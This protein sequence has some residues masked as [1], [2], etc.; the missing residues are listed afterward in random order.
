M[1][2]KEYIKALIRRLGEGDPAAL[3]R[4]R[5]VVGS[6]R[7]RIT[8]DA[9]TVEVRFTKQGLV[10]RT[11]LSNS[12][13]G[14]GLTDRQT[15]LDILD[16]RLE[17]VEAIMLGRLHITGEVEEINR[18][19]LAIEILLDA[20][21]RNPALQELAEQL[22]AESVPRRP[23]PAPARK[24]WYPFQAGPSEQEMLRRLSLL[25]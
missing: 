24:S 15:V 1:S 13:D 3:A 2:T 19:I 5:H 21:A 20:S 9:E 10:V 8:L 17:V 11:E 25:P 6:R 16:A 12:A 14:S 4:L 23:W 22:H 18:I 7:A